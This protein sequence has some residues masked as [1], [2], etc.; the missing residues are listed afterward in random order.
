MKKNVMLTPLVGD[1]TIHGDGAVMAGEDGNDTSLCSGAGE[2]LQSRR[3]R[4]GESGLR[5][6]NDTEWRRAA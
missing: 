5:S 2:V 6:A 4:H 1:D 3:W